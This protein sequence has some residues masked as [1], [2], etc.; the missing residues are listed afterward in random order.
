MASQGHV[1]VN[2]EKQNSLS[3]TTN[4]IIF[5]FSFAWQIELPPVAQTFF[6]PYYP[7]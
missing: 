2:T 1:K 6:L 4:L 5:P 3:L 7:H